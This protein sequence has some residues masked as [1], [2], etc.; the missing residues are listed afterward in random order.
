MKSALRRAALVSAASIVL[1]AAA[2][3]PGGAQTTVETTI[4]HA[5]EA[6]SQGLLIAITPP[7]ETEPAAAVSGATTEGAMTS[8]GPAAS[9]FAD[10]VSILGEEPAHVETSAPPD[11]SD[12]VTGPGTTIGDPGVGEL[13]ILTGRAT[14]S[15]EAEDGLASTENDA[16]FRGARGSLGVELGP[17]GLVEAGV[18][19]GEVSSSAE[20]VANAPR[21]VGAAGSASGLGIELGLTIP[22]LADLCAQLPPG[23]LRDACDALVEA[24]E[25]NTEIDVVLG[26]SEATC[27]WDGD[28]ADCDGSASAATIRLLGQE[29][30]EVAPGETVVI[31]PDPGPTDPFLLRL[32]LGTF[33][34]ETAENPDEA[35]AIATGLSVEL[36]GAE[37]QGPGLVT[38]QLGESTAGVSGDVDREEIII[39]RTGGPVLP[40]LI[41]G[42]ALVAT[43]VG[44]RRFL[45]PR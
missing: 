45:R 6:S 25:D 16:L 43:A 22:G 40:L 8:D 7:G 42:S 4:S 32:S 39:A 9:G 26:G 19:I 12:T 18:T 37:A 1:A 27:S 35:S 21:E 29:P 2:S 38:V 13:E 44:L 23:P 20:A 11:E 15:S 31:P 30:I 17:L 14:S 33:E 10:V 34:K 41:G 24:G 5:A 36:L 28:V 3:S